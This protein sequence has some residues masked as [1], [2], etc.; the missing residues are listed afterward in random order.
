MPRHAGGA[1]KLPNEVHRQKGTEPHTRRRLA[2][3]KEESRLDA[4]KHSMM[5]KDEEDIV[6]L[7]SVEETGVPDYPDS[8]GEKGKELWDQIWV[9]E[10]FWLSPKTDYPSAEHACRCYE[11]FLQLHENYMTQLSMDFP[12]KD[13]HQAWAAASKQLG[14]A[15]NDLGLNPMAR[16]RLGVAEV[17]KTISKMEALQQKFQKKTPRKVGGDE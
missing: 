3:G 1:N 2:S 6:P 4:A 14:D 15:L 8:L 13:S 11:M 16:S 17:K 10:V 5:P 9:P 12:N 7:P